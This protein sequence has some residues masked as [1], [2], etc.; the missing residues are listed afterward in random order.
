MSKAISITALILSILATGLALWRHI[1]HERA[2]KQALRER[3]A[4]LIRHFSPN[5]QKMAADF[6]VTDYPANPQTLEEAFDP[7]V[8]AMEK[9]SATD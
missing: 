4:D 3:E 7:I 5:L 8:R 1:D 2:A 9:I 6:D